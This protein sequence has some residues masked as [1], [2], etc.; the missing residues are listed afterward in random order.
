MLIRS[1][2]LGR[3][4]GARGFVTCR[5]DA[6]AF[7][8]EWRGSWDSEGGGV[9]LSRAIHTLDLMISFL[10]RPDTVD[11]VMA[12]HHLSGVTEVEDTAAVRLTSGS[13]RGLLY[14][15]CAGAEDDP[16]ILEIQAEKG[17]LRLEGASLELRTPQKRETVS[18]RDYG[19][20]KSGHR[21][22]IEDF[23]R[24][25][26]K[27]KPLRIGVASCADTMNAV[28]TA[29]EKGRKALLSNACSA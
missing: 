10:G 9:L 5:T 26:E 17:C 8:D 20:G 21:L 1:G 25:L 7:R 14:A 13:R 2:A 28:L 18:C 6:D 12:N 23:Y 27:G 29:Y 22:C 4:T 24:S 16:P 15:S 19:Q 11:C 3:V